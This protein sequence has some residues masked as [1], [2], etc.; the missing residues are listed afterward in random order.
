MY[1]FFYE[2]PFVNRIDI[3]KTTSSNSFGDM[4]LRDN[5]CS[6]NGLKFD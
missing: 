4:V 2:N 3:F 1:Q 6:R 5:G